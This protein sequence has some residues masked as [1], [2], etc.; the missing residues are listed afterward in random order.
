MDLNRFLTVMDCCKRCRNFAVEE[1]VVRQVV[2]KQMEFE[3]LTA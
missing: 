1:A 2:E 3:V